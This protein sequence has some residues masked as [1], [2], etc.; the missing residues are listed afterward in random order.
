MTGGEVVVLGKT[1]RNF[2][3]GMSGGV[4]Y[5]LD[6]D[7]RLVNTEMVDLQ[8]VPAEDYSRLESIISKFSAETGSNVAAELLKDWGKSVMRF[9]RVMPR[10][11]ARVLR[12]ISEA[13]KSGKDQE[14]AIMEVLNG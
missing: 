14:R 5:L 7:P 6:L 4:A 11:Y 10:D 1:G 2:A 9:T 13:E 3:A 12:V 8:E